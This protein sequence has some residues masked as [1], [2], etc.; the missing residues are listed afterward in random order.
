MRACGETRQQTHNC[1]FDSA[2]DADSTPERGCVVLYQPQQV[3]PP[4]VL[5]LVFD[6]AAL[7]LLFAVFALSPWQYFGRLPSLRPNAGLVAIHRHRAL[8]IYQSK[9]ELRL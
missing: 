1:R 3:G 6:T 5:R 7:R 4:R 9:V 2:T 8:P